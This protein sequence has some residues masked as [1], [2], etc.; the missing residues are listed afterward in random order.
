MI[1]HGQKGYFVGGKVVGPAEREIK[2]FWSSRERKL[3][4]DGQPV[5]KLSTISARCG[6]SVFARKICNW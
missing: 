3:T 2:M 4:L 1:R 6:R 5:K